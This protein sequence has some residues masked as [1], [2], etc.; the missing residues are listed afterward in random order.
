MTR[1]VWKYELTGCFSV[2]Q[3]PCGAEVLTVQV[4]RGQ[5]VLWAMVDPAEEETEQRTFCAFWTGMGFSYN[6][7]MRY[8]GTITRPSDGHTLGDL[9]YHVFERLAS[10]ESSE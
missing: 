7:P 10:T 5:V 4:Q 1:A 6:Q 8:L 2:L 3:M 9:V